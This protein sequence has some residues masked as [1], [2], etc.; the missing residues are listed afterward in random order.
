M[1]EPSSPGLVLVAEDN[2]DDRLLLEYAF[3]TNRL[4]NPHLILEDGQQVIA[5]LSRSG[6]FANTDLPMP[7]LLVLDLQMP[8]KSGLEVLTWVR[9][10]PRFAGLSVVI[11]SGMQSP[12]MVER[13]L[14]LGANSYLFKPGDYSE[15]V[16]FIADNNL[17]RELQGA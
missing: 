5:Y 11:F 6:E 13:A 3:R 7:E 8:H 15:L 4:P 17:M 9:E 10:Q 2:A 1:K 12:Q 14:A 16:R